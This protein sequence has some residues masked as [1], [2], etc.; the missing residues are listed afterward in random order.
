M[1]L[2]KDFKEFIELLNSNNERPQPILFSIRKTQVAEKKNTNLRLVK[3]GKAQFTLVNEH[4]D[5]E[6]N[7]KVGIFFQT[8]IKD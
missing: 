8:L 1:V 2:N 3:L 6:R 4:F 7:E 5:S